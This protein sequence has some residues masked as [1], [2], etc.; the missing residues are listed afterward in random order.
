MGR[1]WQRHTVVPVTRRRAFLLGHPGDPGKGDN[2]RSASSA[3]AL[4]V[5]HQHSF[6]VH[7]IRLSYRRNAIFQRIGETSFDLAQ[8]YRILFLM[9]APLTMYSNRL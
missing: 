7:R 1:R 5:S 3:S 8:N 9:R 4:L 6:I 2:Q